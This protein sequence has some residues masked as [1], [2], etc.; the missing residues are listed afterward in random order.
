MGICGLSDT[1]VYDVKVIWIFCK[2][3]P[4]LSLYF[5]TCK[6]FIDKPLL[7]ADIQA[8]QTVLCVS[9]MHCSVLLVS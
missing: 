3:L 8:I 1:L 6:R 5:R 9:R 2:L 7:T 4:F